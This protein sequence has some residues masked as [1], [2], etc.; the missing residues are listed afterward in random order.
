MIQNDGNEGLVLR[1]R[2]KKQGLNTSSSAPGVRTLRGVVLI[3]AMALLAAACGSAV[4]SNPV[5]LSASSTAQFATK[6]SMIEVSPST[7][8][9]TTKVGPYWNLVSYDVASRTFAFLTPPSISQRGGFAIAANG[10]G[11]GLVAFYPYGSMLFSPY[12]YTS[13]VPVNWKT[14]QLPDGLL[15]IQHAVVDTGTDIVAAV[16]DH[17]GKE[18]IIY[19]AL[20]GSRTSVATYPLNGLQ[21]AGLYASGSNVTVDLVRGNH[22][23]L[24]LFNVASN[25]WKTLASVVTPRLELAQGFVGTTATPQAMETVGCSLAPQN[26]HDVVVWRLTSS[27]EAQ[28]EKLVVAGSLSS[29]GVAS[30]SASYLTARKGHGAVQI[31]VSQGSSPVQRELSTSYVDPR[32]TSEIDG[33]F[34]AYNLTNS[35]TLLLYRGGSSQSV[36]TPINIYLR[37]VLKQAQSGGVG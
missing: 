10:V 28:P 23:I 19:G 33:T 36:A 8:W 22:H 27:G 7:L 6:A 37:R 32:A 18:A 16:R 2:R 34:I 13:G 1:W 30:A 14:G 4:S 25:T 17:S 35:G 9:L 3:V 11:G 29:C 26:H 31:V 20:G 12:F 5:E 15:P 24:E 21:I